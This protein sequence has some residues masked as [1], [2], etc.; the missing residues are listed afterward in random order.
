MVAYGGDETEHALRRRVPPAATP[1]GLALL[2]PA[3]GG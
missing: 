1:L 2:V 3:A